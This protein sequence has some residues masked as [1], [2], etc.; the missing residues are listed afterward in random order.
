MRVKST[1]FIA[2]DQSDKD[3]WIVDGTDQILGRLASAI[4]TKI[5]GKDNVSYSPHHDNGDFVVVVNC[6]N[7]V[8]TTKEKKIWWHRVRP[9]YC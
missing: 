5:K 3:W 2:L 4:A 9:F 1:K 8:C 7:I 6:K